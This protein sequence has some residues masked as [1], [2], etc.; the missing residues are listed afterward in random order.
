[1]GFAE[2][3]PNH[4]PSPLLSTSTPKTTGDHAERVHSELMSATTLYMMSVTTGAALA[5]STHP[6][7][8]SF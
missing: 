4:H 6:L 2:K 8:L 1:M 3:T 5:T 7:N